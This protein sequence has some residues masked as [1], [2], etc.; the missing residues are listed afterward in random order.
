MDYRQISEITGISQEELKKRHDAWMG[1]SRKKKKNPDLKLIAAFSGLSISSVSGYINNKKGSISEK[2]ARMLDSLLSV[3]DYRPS[4][5]AK[6]LRSANKMSIGFIAP[7]TNSPSTEYSVEILKG[8]KEEARKYGY[9]VDIYD[10]GPDEQSDFISR[11]PFLGLVDGLIL[12]SSSITSESLSPLIQENIPVFHINPLKEELR[13]PFVGSINSD[14]APFTDLLDHLFTDHKYRN[15]LLVYVPTEGHLQRQKKLDLFLKAV[16]RYE[17]P[18]QAGRNLLTVPFYTYKDGN[19]AWKRAKTINPDA[20]VYICLSDVIA[21][22]FIRAQQKKGEITA[23]T[24]Y[25]DFEV[26]EFFDITTVDQNIRELGTN[27]FQQL[28]YSIQYI[29]SQGSFPEYK[30]VKAS[31]RLIKRESCACKAG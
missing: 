11:L 25:G 24:G 15:P 18:F 4:H 13:P 26:G 9:F 21:V 10:I 16:E 27:A 8:V 20:D 2:K 7:I 3:L 17:I 19:A 30:S 22:S 12:V 14:T 31:T 5:A 6:K 1:S 29:Q 28:F 23:V